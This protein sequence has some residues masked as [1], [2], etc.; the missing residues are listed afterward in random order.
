MVAFL[1]LSINSLD[2]SVPLLDV[3]LLFPTLSNYEQCSQEYLCS[4][5]LSICLLHWQAG[6]LP[7]VPPGKPNILSIYLIIF[8]GSISRSISPMT[9]IDNNLLRCKYSRK[10]QSWASRTLL[11]I[12]RQILHSLGRQKAVWAYWKPR[13]WERE[14]RQWQRL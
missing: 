8:L 14:G 2:A 3:R 4:N 7:P 9:K 1:W 10:L 5:I 12:D 11:R 6:S 13:R